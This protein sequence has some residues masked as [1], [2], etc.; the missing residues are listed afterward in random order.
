MDFFFFQTYTLLF[1]Q[2]DLLSLLPEDNFT[3]LKS[4]VYALLSCATEANFFDV[5]STFCSIQIR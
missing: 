3:I 1:T 4:V 5:P 2:L